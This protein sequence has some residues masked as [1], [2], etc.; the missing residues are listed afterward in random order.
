M[1]SIREH[2]DRPLA[3]GVSEVETSA[4]PIKVITEYQCDGYGPLTINVGAMCNMPKDGA[5]RR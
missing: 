1:P 2:L 4:E 3:N 5:Q